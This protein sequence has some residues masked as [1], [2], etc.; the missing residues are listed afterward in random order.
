MFKRKQKE[1]YLRIK[2]T[3]THQRKYILILWLFSLIGLLLL[4][5]QIDGIVTWLYQ[6]TPIQVQAAQPSGHGPYSYS[7]T[8]GTDRL[9]QTKTF[10][11]PAILLEDGRAI[12]PGNALHADIGTKGGGLFSF[13]K[14]NLYFSTSDNSDPRT[15]G[16]KYT[17]RLPISLDETWMIFVYVWVMFLTGLISAVFWISMPHRRRRLALIAVGLSLLVIT[18][19]FLRPQMKDAYSYLRTRVYIL[20]FTPGFYERRG[21]DYCNPRFNPERIGKPK[22]EIDPQKDYDFARLARARF[23]LSGV[24]RHLALK[25]IFDTV[26]REA[27]TNTEKHLALLQFLQKSSYHNYFPPIN[28]TGRSVYDPLVYLELGEMWCGDVA[29]LAIDLFASAGYP[30]RVVQLGNHQIAEIYYDNDWHYFDADLFSGGDIVLMPDG[31]IPSVD[32]LSRLESNPLDSLPTYYEQLI[33]RSCFDKK[34]D[35]KSYGAAYH[36]FSSLSYEESKSQTLF[37]V[38]TASFEQEQLDQTYFGWFTYQVITDTERTLRPLDLHA[39]PSVVW[40]DK[41]EMDSSSG[42]A[43]VSFHANDP[44]HDL[45]GYRVFIS[46]QSRGW[47]YAAFFGAEEARPYWNNPGGWKPE[48]YD[49]FHLLPPSDV[50][51]IQTESGQVE[52]AIPAG[53][54]LFISIMAYDVYGEQ[55]GRKLYPVSNEIVISNLK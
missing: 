2:T 15:N 40:I 12:G 47:D 26:T 21:S 49:V 4:W 27:A 17:L 3:L 20:T 43:A 55:V 42:L 34:A 33:V 51:L 6:S 23:Y 14:G 36:Y 30:G 16:R 53:E 29:H 19:V 22:S 8:V 24:D 7:L 11:S 41:I 39:A 18:G 37:Y 28:S 13:W 31:S 25:H 38:K 10:E 5:L 9:S 32:E 54:T 35:G 48:M 46:T 44:D 50:D 52:I 1:I 45:A